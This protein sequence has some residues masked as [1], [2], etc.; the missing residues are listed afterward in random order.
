MSKKLCLAYVGDSERRGFLYHEYEMTV[1]DYTVGECFLKEGDASR[2]MTLGNVGYYVHE[3]HRGNSYAAAA[4]TE[5]LHFAP[6]YNIDRLVICCKIDNIASEKSCIRAGAYYDT[7]VTLDEKDDSYAYG[8][9][10]V[11]RYFLDV[12]NNKKQ[13][14]KIK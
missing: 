3:E 1:G 10:Y 6:R 5:L 7:T 12:P 8:T 14:E 13:K 9:R 4:L 2:I 11:K